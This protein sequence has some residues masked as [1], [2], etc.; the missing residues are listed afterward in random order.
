VKAKGTED[1]LQLAI[2]L[3]ARI[4]AE[5]PELL[6]A[7][8]SLLRR[9]NPARHS[10]DFA[11]V[12]WF[13]KNYSFRA[14]QIPIVQLLWRAWEDQTPDVRVSTLIDAVDHE[15][16]GELKISN[17]FRG[18]PAWGT[19]IQG[20]VKGSLRLVPPGSGNSVPDE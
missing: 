3:S 20:P 19:M 11:S 8:A 14:A 1:T 16:E 9:L 10:K 5:R 18:H 6:P 4:A 17:I 15:R 13:G 2:A 12:H 7:I